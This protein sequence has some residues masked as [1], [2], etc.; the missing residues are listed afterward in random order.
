MCGIAGIIDTRSAPGAQAILSMIEGIRYRG[1]DGDGHVCLQNDGVALG[2]RRLSIIDLSEAGA[3]PMQS[4]D[5]RYWLTYNGEIYNYVEI[6]KELEALGRTFRSHSDTEVLLTAYAEWG[7][8]CLQRFMGMYAFAIWDTQSKELFAARDRMGIKPF[9]FQETPGG[10]L[11]FASEIKSILAVSRESHGVDPSV[12]DAYMQFGYVPGSATMHRG[13]R[14]LLPAQ[15]LRWR[16]GATTTGSYWDLS[17]DRISQDTLEQSAEKLTR[18]LEDSVALH[19]RADV[20]VGVFLSGGLDSS[21]M[22]A[23]LSKGATAGLKTFSV[24]YDFGG[25]FDETPFARQVAER[26]AT[27]HHEIRMQPRDFVEFIPGFVRH[28]DEP[29]ADSASLSLYYVAKLARQHVTVCLSGEGSDELFAGY[30]FYAYNLAI[31]RIR[32]LVGGA[33]PGAAA[34]LLPKQG[35][36][37][38]ARKYLEMASK[39]LERRYNG[40]STYEAQLQRGLYSREFAQQGAQGNPEVNGFLESLF[41]RT[42]GWD[43]LARMLYFDTRTWLVDDLLI[44]ADRMSMACSIELRVP[45][46]DHRLVEFAATLPPAQKIRGMN[47]K[48]VLKEAMRTRLPEAIV[49]RRKMGFPTPIELMFRGELYGYARQLLLSPAALSR[50]YFDRGR[51][52]KLLDDHRDGRAQ[53]HREI[54]QLVVLEEWQK[55]FGASRAA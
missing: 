53:N 22:V 40:I 25:Q 29:V 32:G 1:P 6:K 5:G 48:R 45:F 35:R 13:I 31:E 50:G 7:A 37:A 47:V 17:F 39:P 46:L 20:P 8:E 27:D 10:G 4:A 41:N 26:F 54:W 52:E 14:R 28:M 36:L 55:Q 11:I 24:A 12:I 2:H 21:T 23:L 18:M 42:R 49:Q 34:S 15:W 19:L 3:Q 33:L 51:I 38:K 30:D 43:P 9:Y 44:K 16:K